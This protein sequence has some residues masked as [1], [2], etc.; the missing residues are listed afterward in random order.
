[1]RGAGSTGKEQCGIY[2]ISV[3]ISFSNTRWYLGASI[4]FKL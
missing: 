4:S 3:H 2:C 1:M